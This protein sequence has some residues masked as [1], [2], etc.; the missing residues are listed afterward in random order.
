MTRVSIDERQDSRERKKERK[1]CDMRGGLHGGLVGNGLVV[2]WSL[3][4]WNYGEQSYEAL[5]GIHIASTETV[6]PPCSLP[7]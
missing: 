7:G 5:V 3:K 4:E 2:P 1:T 6:S